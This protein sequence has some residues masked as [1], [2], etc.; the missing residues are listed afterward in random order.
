MK[1]KYKTKIKVNGIDIDSLIDFK[2]GEIKFSDTKSSYHFTIEEKR[3]IQ[4]KIRKVLKIA[5]ENK[6]KR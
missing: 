5:A 1:T 6:F 3:D 4:K 2:T